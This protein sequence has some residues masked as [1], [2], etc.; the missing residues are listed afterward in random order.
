MAL[1]GNAPGPA[2]KS[3]LTGTP[4]TEVVAEY[5]SPAGLTAARE[6]R[7]WTCGELGQRSGLGEFAIAM[8]EAGQSL[9][10]D[11]ALARLVRTLECQ[12]G[13]LHAGVPASPQLAELQQRRASL[14][15]VDPTPRMRDLVSAI[16][17][18]VPR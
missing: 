8:W 14:L 18:S 15:T 4:Y 5:F 1:A 9:P 2:G 17:A 6:A 10:S 13:T 3:R 11:P 16:S 12:W 7:G